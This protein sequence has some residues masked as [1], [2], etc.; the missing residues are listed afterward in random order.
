MC[1]AI[2]RRGDQ[3]LSASKIFALNFRRP[4]FDASNVINAFRHQRFLHEVLLNEFLDVGEVI[5][6]FRH[7][8]FLHGWFW[9]DTWARDL[10]INAFRHQRFLHHRSDRQA[11][12][13]SCDQRLSASKIFALDACDK[14]SLRKVEV[15]N[16][17]RHQRFLHVRG[18]GL[19]GNKSGDQRLSAS[20]IF[21]QVGKGIRPHFGR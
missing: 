21:A 20:K 11:G 13:E 1:P 17:F 9:W 4:D 7:Q 10:V 12:S 5:N 6:A 15:I 16:A 8:R 18:S 3:R 2:Y 14:F 19:Q